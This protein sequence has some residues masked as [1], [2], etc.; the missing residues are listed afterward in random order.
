MN[1]GRWTQTVTTAAVI[2]AGL[3]VTAGSASERRPGLRFVV[4]PAGAYVSG[5]HDG[6]YDEKPVRIVNV[7]AFEIMRTEVPEITYAACVTAGRCAQHRGKVRGP[8]FPVTGVSYKDA[9]S[10]CKWLKW[11]LPT[12]AEWEKAARGTDQRRFPWGDRDERGGFGRANCG[13][14]CDQKTTGKTPPKKFPGGR[15]LHLVTA[16]VDGASPYGALNLAGNV[17]E[18]VADWYG[19]GYGYWAP[20]QDP[21]GPN[22]GVYR[23]VRGGELSQELEVVRTTNRYWASPAAYSDRRGFRCAR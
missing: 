19:E 15:R 11:R 14:G 3:V 1:R 10:C 12:E 5:S 9:M 7:S 6:Q 17:E 20:R 8:M 2:A 23:S 4:V 21:K 22:T 16:N 13:Q 18:W